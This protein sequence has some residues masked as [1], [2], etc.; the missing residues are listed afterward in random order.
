MS[1]RLLKAI[2]ILVSLAFRKAPC[3][4]CGSKNTQGTFPGNWQCLDCHSYAQA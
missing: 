3:L 2:R 1:K 4:G